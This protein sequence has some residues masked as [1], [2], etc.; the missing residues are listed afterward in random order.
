MAG[1]SRNRV[2]AGMAAVLLAVVVVFA[3]ES[4]VTQDVRVAG[5]PTMLGV[6]ALPADPAAEELEVFFQQL[7]EATQALGR[8]PRRDDPQN[9]MLEALAHEH[10]DALVQ[11]HEGYPSLRYY[12]EPIIHREIVRRGGPDAR[13]L[14]AI[15]LHDPADPDAAWSYVTDIARATVGQRRVSAAD[16]QVG[17]LEALAEEQ[18]PVLIGA[19]G[20]PEIRFYALRAIRRSATEEHKATIIAALPGQPRLIGIVRRQGWGADARDAL[21]LGLERGVDYMPRTWVQAVVELQDPVTYDALAM[22]LV[23]S[24]GARTYYMMMR[25]LPGIDLD[26]AVCAAWERVR[27]A[28]AYRRELLEVSEFAVAHGHAPALELLINTLPVG[29]D[30]ATSQAAMT[31]QTVLGHIEYGGSNAEVR[32]WYEAHRDRLRFC[33]QSRC[34]YVAGELR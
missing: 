4:I 12:L 1:P 20:L 7:D 10:L 25:D 22:H 2:E 26:A 6:D 3:W 24:R 8:N 14:A 17:M 28:P 32:S 18:M 29:E 33:R 19:V 16:P 5:R 31:R 30:E 23:R 11:A 13:R 15:V 21:V 34:F 9:Q 27:A